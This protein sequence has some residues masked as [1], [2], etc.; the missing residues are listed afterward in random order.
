MPV[1]CY[2]TNNEIMKVMALVI[3]LAEIINQLVNNTFLNKIKRKQPRLIESAKYLTNGGSEFLGAKRGFL[4]IRQ[5][6]QR[7]F[8][9]IV[10]NL[11]P[12]RFRF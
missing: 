9:K 5:T 12:K 11:R 2:F 6:S 3:C 4:K 7:L 1:N 10:L 8:Y